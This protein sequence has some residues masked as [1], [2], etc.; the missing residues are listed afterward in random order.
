LEIH[1]G[2]KMADLKK[3]QLHKY[4]NF[5]LNKNIYSKY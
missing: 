2:G 3:A 1:H 4:F 5:I